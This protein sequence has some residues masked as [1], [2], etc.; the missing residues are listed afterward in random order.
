[1]ADSR[2]TGLLT[3]TVNTFIN[4]GTTSEYVTLV[5]A[6]HL[7]GHYTQ[8]TTTSSRV[9]YALPTS[10]WGG[11]PEGLVSSRLNTRVTDAA[12]TLYTIR[13]LRTH[14]DGTYAQMIET[15]TDVL[16]R[17]S[18]HPT[19]PLSIPVQGTF[20]S[21]ASGGHS[22]AH[23]QV[24]LKD[25]ELSPSSVAD[26]VVT[27]VGTKGKFIKNGPI[28]A[29][30][31]S[32][33]TGS[34]IKDLRTYLFFF[35]NTVL[36]PVPG[37]AA[38]EPVTKT[39][40]E[41]VVR[42]GGDQTK[43]MVDMDKDLHVI[44]PAK[45]Q[46]IDSTVAPDLLMGEGMVDGH[47]MGGVF[48]EGSEGFD[49]EGTKSE[50]GETSMMT[51]TINRPL[52]NTVMLQPSAVQ[53]AEEVTLFT[54]ADNLGLTHDVDNEIEK[55]LLRAR[56]AQISGGEIIADLRPSKPLEINL[57]TYTVGQS[58]LPLEQVV[59]FS[60][61][62][63]GAMET[64]VEKSVSEKH[65][66]MNQ[67]EAKSVSDIRARFNLDRGGDESDLP[68]VTYVGFA[69]FVTTIA[70]TVVVFTPR[71]DTPSKI[72]KPSV[73]K[74]KEAPQ[75]PTTFSP[76]PVETPASP[77]TLAPR[78]APSRLP[79]EEVIPTSH[80]E[81]FNLQ[82]SVHHS[83]V[84]PEMETQLVTQTGETS[85]RASIKEAVEEETPSHVFSTVSTHRFNTF[86]LYPTGLVSSIGGTIVRNEMTTLL[87]TY[88][89]GTYIQGQ[90]AQIVQST[91]S[92]FY[93]VSRSATPTLLVTP[94]VQPVAA[95]RGPLTPELT[96]EFSDIY[97]YYDY[98]GFTT[99]LGPVDDVLDN[100]L[101]RSVGSNPGQQLIVDTV[102]E[103]PA[104]EEFE[105][106]T[107]QP[108]EESGGT[109]TTL[110]HYTTYFA[111]GS[112]S[113][114]TRYETSSVFLPF[115]GSQDSTTDPTPTD[116]EL[117]PTQVS[118]THLT[119]YTYYTTLFVDGSS[120][121]SSRI[122]VLTK[123]AIDATSSLIPSFIAP[124][125]SVAPVKPLLTTTIS[126]TTAT[127]A[128]SNTSEDTTE[129]PAGEEDLAVVEA[130]SMDESIPTTESFI[131]SMSESISESSTDSSGQDV[132]E[133]PKAALES[134]LIPEDEVNVA[135]YPRTYYTTY[136]YFTTYYR[137]GTSS[138]VSSLETLT[139]VVTDPTDHDQHQTLTP[140]V[141]TYPV[142]YYTTYT[143]WTTFFKGTSTISTSSEKTLSN[144]VTPAVKETATPH[145]DLIPVIDASPTSTPSPSATTAYITA[146]TPT[147]A[148]TTFYTTYTYY[149]STY[150]GEKTIVNSRLETI[151]NVV[152]S[153]VLPDGV[154]IDGPARPRVTLDNVF[155]FGTTTTATS[156]A[157]LPLDLFSFDEITTSK[158]EATLPLDVFGFGT[159]SP[160][161]TQPQFPTKT[162]ST[163]LLSTIRGSTVVDG[164]TTVFSTNII[165]TVVDGL[166]AQ[167]QSTTNIV[168]LPS[169]E[170]VSED[171][172]TTVPFLFN[173]TTTTEELVA[174]TL[175]LFKPVELEG[176]VGA[177]FTKP[178]LFATPTLES[179]LQDETTGPI[180]LNVATETLPSEVT[181]EEL[182]DTSSV[183]VSKPKSKST[184]RNQFPGRPSSNR[185]RPDILPFL[186][187][188]NSRSATIT[189]DGLTP[190]VTAT[191][192]D[193][194]ETND[195][196]TTTTTVNRPFRFGFLQATTTTT[197]DGTTTRASAAPASV[198][199]RFQTSKPGGPR[200]S[201]RPG[202]FG[203][204]SVRGSSPG[205][206]FGASSPGAFAG[207][208][209]S[210]GFRF[211]TKRSSV[212]PGSTQTVKPSSVFPVLA[213]T[214]PPISDLEGFEEEPILDEF[215]TE[216]EFLETDDHG[217]NFRPFSFRPRQ[218]ESNEPGSRASVPFA[219][220][221]RR[222][223]TPQNRPNTPSRF[224]PVSKKS[225]ANN[226]EDAVGKKRN[227]T[228]IRPR[229]TTPSPRQGF[230]LNR[231]S[232]EERRRNRIQQSRPDLSK[233]FARRHPFKKDLDNEATEVEPVYADPSG[234][235][236][237]AEEILVRKK[238]Q[239]NSFGMRTTSRG[240]TRMAR[241]RSR[242]TIPI[243]SRS[244]DS[245][246]I[247]PP[248]SRFS[249]VARPRPAAPAVP[250]ASPVTPKNNAQ[251]F[252]LRGG[253]R[254]R[255]RLP[256]ATPAP[257]PA[258][259]RNPPSAPKRNP[260]SAPQRN[261]PPA[262]KR[263]PPPAPKRNPPPAPKRNPQP[264]RQA[265]R[266]SRTSLPTRPRT[267]SRTRDSVPLGNI[268]GRGFR[269]P[270]TDN[271]F[272]ASTK[273]T[274]PRTPSSPIRRPTLR[275]TTVTDTNSNNNANRRPPP[276]RGSNPI[277]EF[278][279][280]PSPPVATE[281]PAIFPSD[282]GGFL[283]QDQLT[284]TRE[285]PVKATIPL[286]EDG[287]TIM[288]EVITA[289]YQ[290]EIIQPDQITQT[291]IDGVIR[292][293]LSSVDAGNEVTNYVVDPV[294]TISITH[295]PT[296]V[297][298]RRTSVPVTI[299][300]TAFNVITITQTKQGSDIQQLLQL[301]LGQQQQQQNPLLAA[302]GLNGQQATSH[303]IHTSTYV[304]TVTNVM[305]TAVPIIFRGK[306][307]HT[308]IVESEV[309]VITVT[310]LNTQTVLAAP[311]G[312][313]FGNPNPINQLLPLLLQG[314]LQQQSAQNRPS[315]E[316]AVQPT[317]TDA[318]L[319]EQLIKQQQKQ[320]N[321]KHLE[322]QKLPSPTPTLEETSVVTMYV[323]GRRPGEFSTVLS[324]VV[325]SGQ[326][327]R[328]KRGS[329]KTKEVE[330]TVLPHYIETDKGLFQL[331][332]VYSKDEMDWFIM[333]AMN[334]ID[335]S[336]ITK[337]TPNIDS[338]FGDLAHDY[339]QFIS[340]PSNGTH[341]FRTVPFLWSGPAEFAPLKRN[342]RSAQ[343]GNTGEP[344]GRKIE[345]GTL[346]QVVAN[347][348]GKQ[349]AFGELE[350][351]GVIPEQV[352]APTTYYTT[353][354]YY[355]TLV[356]DAGHEF[357]QSSEE[358]LTQLVTRGNL[359]IEDLTKTTKG[360]KENTS[361]QEKF[362]LQDAI[363]PG[364][365]R[366]VPD[367]VFAEPSPP[368]GPVIRHR[369]PDPDFAAESD[370]P[371]VGEEQ[372]ISSGSSHFDLSHLESEL[373]EL[374]R[375]RRI[376]LT[377]KR[378]LGQSPEDRVRAVVTRRRPVNQL[379]ESPTRA[380]LG[381]TSVE[382]IHLQI[383]KEHHIEDLQ[384]LNPSL[385][386]GV[387]KLSHEVM[388]FEE[389]DREE[390]IAGKLGS[391]RRMRVTVTSRRIIQLTE[392]AEA[393]KT[394][395]LSGGRRRIV[396]TRRL[397][398]PTVVASPLRPLVAT[399]ST[400]YTIYS[401]LY[402]LYEGNSLVSESQREVTVSNEV[403]PTAV[404]VLPTFQTGMAA[405]G[406]YT[407][408]TGSSVATLGERIHKSL[409]TQIFLSSVTLVNLTPEAIK[410]NAQTPRTTEASHLP[411]SIPS[412]L[413]S[414][415][416]EED[417]VLP[418]DTPFITTSS[419]RATQERGQTTT[420]QTAD[421]KPLEPLVATA[422][423][424]SPTPSRS[425]IRS[426]GRGSVRFTAPRQ[427][428]KVTLTRRRPIT[429]SSNR[430]LS[431][432][433]RDHSPTLSPARES[434]PILTP[435]RESIKTRIPVR[436]PNHAISLAH[437]PT[438]TLP[439]AREA[440]PTLTQST[441]VDFLASR[442]PLESTTE[443]PPVDEPEQPDLFEE[444]LPL[445]SKR[446]STESEFRFTHG[447]TNPTPLFEE[448]L[449]L[450]SERPSTESEFRFTHGRTTPTPPPVDDSFDLTPTEK[451]VLIEE[452]E[453]IT[454]P[455][456][457]PTPAPTPVRP[458]RP[459]RK[460]IRR[461]DIPII[462]RPSFERPSRPFI[463]QQSV[464]ETTPATEPRLR[465]TSVSLPTTEPTEAQ[466]KTEPSEAPP[467][468][469]PEQPAEADYVY[470]DYYDDY[471]YYDGE[472][473]IPG[474]LVPEQKL[475]QPD[476]EP[477]QPKVQLSPELPP[478]STLL[479]S[480]LRFT[481]PTQIET[482][483]SIFDFLEH[484]K[485]DRTSTKVIL[486]TTTRESDSSSTDATQTEEP[487]APPPGLVYTT[488][489]T[490]T[491][492]PILGGEHSITL[493]IMTSSLTTPS[494]TLPFFNTASPSLAEP[495]PTTPT[496]LSSPTT[497]LPSL[498]PSSPP[499]D[500]IQTP[501]V[502]DPLPEVTSP[503]ASVQPK[504][505]LGKLHHWSSLFGHLPLS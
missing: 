267:S 424:E 88:V 66:E 215:E 192:A 132:T 240:T 48:I 306:A 271:N 126:T 151:T 259:Q 501:V 34:Y 398:Q 81:S 400:Y 129:H 194:T 38:P 252:T 410:E 453:E 138:I 78:L 54:M 228:P 64:S 131:E 33:F 492:L 90:Y 57:P 301:L 264:T 72:I 121:V 342:V 404:S 254:A 99:E 134:S 161:V 110:T 291:E 232:P 141:P 115:F 459:P 51:V 368:F 60:K 314:Q 62:G 325:L 412:I 211:S 190:T 364:K 282:D 159:S 227:T 46:T 9:F 172:S 15:M 447:R 498:E 219:L 436:Q 145:G 354:T 178:A 246:P 376:V 237:E 409:T 299:S 230:R 478:H 70:N 276:A 105:P 163:G 359:R 338:I 97:D 241:A 111:D 45:T 185:R 75:S 18:S 347:G 455:K 391:R 256:S 269:R 340:P 405:S 125:P 86:D 288:K 193:T 208:S 491:L 122:E 120:Q 275:R 101:G 445:P 165:G 450:P 95:T 168:I 94:A 39:H 505:S 143:Y 503:T 406:L 485:G 224:T 205:F 91:S 438:H 497:L 311:A 103:K 457:P 472:E 425:G 490:T 468:K 426:N 83:A 280:R 209:S 500:G 430:P 113:V 174:S 300:S 244:R 69:D 360:K 191:P 236:L 493:T 25:S 92:I 270:S 195:K 486:P 320:N 160:E 43:I 467:V 50:S 199:F 437:E 499:G 298:T 460:S 357:V 454:T 322:N 248:T 260:P 11:Q 321:L 401:Y 415:L 327:T 317:K 154:T 442:E 156:K 58:N 130:V 188:T 356:N 370:P 42:K 393:D 362:T 27:L 265:S 351:P 413:Q 386:N 84:K 13:Y 4:S 456:P 363:L 35:G 439:P 274:P 198:R 63:R 494:L 473:E 469:L 417:L 389:Q 384:K 49:M 480:R 114:S 175:D 231:L 8:L 431:S 61:N 128:L 484:L 318:V 118:N 250:A 158:S 333:S 396:V 483:T 279:N 479:D 135:F 309:E 218:K 127:T 283:I 268:R 443:P 31:F 181:T 383:E 335:V 139:N 369:M 186:R 136:T 65:Q 59:A 242:D 226:P 189:R 102:D 26:E 167:I 266:T 373:P 233:H 295:T 358:T 14:I 476:T 388:E 238:R 169:S 341:S 482:T 504:S 164:T 149:T 428:V 2:P 204:S 496:A 323:S 466:L 52:S 196:D 74:T 287:K 371:Q 40:T 475:P 285:V 68:T 416:A 433:N 331:P 324:T 21:H 140:V 239:A 10:L 303:I 210:G 203:P 152:S 284:V 22:R 419:F 146:V 495:S 262:P 328:R 343:R 162:K 330:A 312:I 305:S 273:F 32:V 414:S 17:P 77:T 361:V 183:T 180:P 144:V 444:E 28:H 434:I 16:S 155:G 117:E 441:S 348:D 150:I 207:T 89:Y 147:Q 41:V 148:V 355:T 7:N 216:G 352:Q 366:P 157:T 293:L 307:V 112:T 107:P 29:T 286:V 451:T 234:E 187:R 93:L 377:R 420:G 179:S 253:L 465:F 249:R 421:I 402:T 202:L 142:T 255:G 461:D 462:R 281:P 315:R 182:G 263:N 464:E 448:E 119:T 422:I 200:G 407:L 381:V 47:V 390:E 137:A 108:P 201:S 176:V 257:T 251:Q 375:P 470:E 481:R 308:T 477:P 427:K 235:P 337:V 397:P 294:D 471:Y 297:G 197:N 290:T 177:P 6:T 474:Q 36:P 346:Q 85:V 385:D 382:P 289:S 379:V 345:D 56:K 332:D 87:T 173:P 488:F 19:A 432:F 326:A 100:A 319:L 71:T 367:P 302:L 278:R 452:V 310:E 387:G 489:A 76:S 336:G 423:S 258:P 408:E 166:Y 349:P 153:S 82:P 350:V 214:A 223:D 458:T 418:T 380:A 123:D 403:E 44:M 212:F 292:L 435:I 3:S 24:S 243:A 213:T 374:Q 339:Y 55:N 463:R 133:G 221:N 184:T 353:F 12:T 53:P 96:T 245:L 80:T 20:F 411:S 446:P 217:V 296:F 365:P 30:T 378:P 372:L 222:P 247:P 37:V 395:T 429:P 23:V 440:I 171:V 73:S 1:M 399:V 449:P 106:A 334:E 67:R 316:P 124:T 261:P 109:F 487:V 344:K 394:T 225:V 98:E 104:V 220:F 304:T 5:R 170:A 116:V 272:R 313:P 277:K 392:T 229:S 79:E 206:R 502:A 329:D